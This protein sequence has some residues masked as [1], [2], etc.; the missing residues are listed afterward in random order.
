MNKLNISSFGQPPEDLDQSIPLEPMRIKTMGQ[1]QDAMKAL[2]TELVNTHP[3]KLTAKQRDS[4]R[5]VYRQVLLNVINNSLRRMYSAFPRGKNAYEKGGYWHKLGLTYTFI[6]AAVDRLESEGLIVQMKGF[7]NRNTGSSRITRIFALD[8][9]FSYID[10][11]QVVNSVEFDWDDSTPVGLKNFPYSA[12]SLADNHPDVK[13]VRAINSFLK[14]HHWILRSPIRIIYSNN[15]VYSGR[16]YTRFQNMN[17]ELRAGMLIDGKPTVELD[18]KSNHLMML[19]AMQGLPLPNDPYQDIADRAG[20]TRDEVKQ[21]ATVA[22]GSPN[23]VNGFKALNAKGF[24]NKK[25]QH[26]NDALLDLFPGVP[27]FRGFGAALQSLEGQI[28]LDVIFAGARRGIVVLPIH[29]SFITTTEHKEWLKDEMLKQW[30]IHVK[31][32]AVTRVEQK[33]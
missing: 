22:I 3:T 10:I 18:F 2:L 30:S 23:R 15:P 19:I 4:L 17:K 25:S 12:D 5:S 1:Q 16:V 33:G 9:L 31:E 32:G 24:T 28:T 20:V 11:E 21:F 27:L 29:D 8:K 26:I 13:R 6:V 14:N 7:Y